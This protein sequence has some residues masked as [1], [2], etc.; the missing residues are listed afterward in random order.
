M[1]GHFGSLGYLQVSQV[2][3][4]RYHLVLRKKHNLVAQ[5][6]MASLMGLQQGHLSLLQWL[7]MFLECSPELQYWKTI[8][9]S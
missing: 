3:S 1:L 9:A 5:D 7:L 8:L 4:L 2:D 6:T